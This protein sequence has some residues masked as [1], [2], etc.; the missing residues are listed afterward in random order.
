[1]SYVIS[2]VVTHGGGN[3]LDPFVL[4]DGDDRLGVGFKSD[5]QTFSIVLFLFISTQP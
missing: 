2:F 3:F 4:A 1:M 5:R